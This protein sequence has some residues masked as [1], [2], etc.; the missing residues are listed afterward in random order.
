MRFTANFLIGCW[1]LFFVSLCHAQQV[2]VVDALTG[3]PIEDVRIYSKDQQHVTNQNGFFS[4]MELKENAQVYISHIGYE[5]ITM[6]TKE[7]LK[8]NLIRLHPDTQQLNEIVLS[9]ARS[10]DERKRVSK[11]VAI[12]GQK[13][14]QLQ[15]SSTSADVL[16]SASGIRIQK[17]QGGGGSPVIRGLEANRILLVVDGVRMNNAIYRSGHIQNAITIDPQTLE[18]AEIIYGPSSVGYGSDALGGVVHYYTKTP[19]IGSHKPWAF[20]MSNS[21]DTRHLHSIN[22]LDITHSKNRWASLSSV[23]LSNFGDLFMGN[24]RNHGYSDWGLVPTYSKNSREHFYETETPN[25]RPNLQRNTAYNQLDILQKF[26]F[27]TDNENQWLLNMQY[28]TSSDIPRFDKLSERR[29]GALR[30]AE[31]YYGPQ[32]RLFVS[33]RY[34]FS[35]SSK[36]LREGIIT[37]AYQ[38][39]EE[40]R[41]KRKFGS[42]DRES[43]IENLDVYSLNA[44][45][46]ART[47]PGK[48]LAY[49]LEFTHNRL[50]SVGCSQALLIQHNNIIGL[51]TKSPIATRYPSDGSTYTTVAVYGDYRVDL[52]EKSTLDAGLRFTHTR[53]KADWKDQALIDARLDMAENQNNAINASIGYVYR[54][55]SQWEWRTVVAS[56]FRAPNIDDIGKI[57]ENHGRISVPNPYLK[58]EYAYTAD[59]GITR[60]FKN[61]NAYIQLNAYYTLLDNFI[62]RDQYLIPSDSSTSSD[63]TILFMNDEVI[64]QANVNLGAANLRGAS[65]SWSLNPIKKWRYSGSFSYTYGQIKRDHLPMPSILPYFGNQEVIYQSQDLKLRFAHHF[66]S[67]KNPK[68]YSW[69]GEDGLEET[70]LINPDALE[71]IDRFAGSPSWSRFDVS[72]HYNATSS[73]TLG[74]HFF[75]ILDTHY[76]E[77]ASGISAPGRSLL[78]RIDYAF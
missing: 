32:K 72:A 58:P 16:G 64:T 76:K 18:R 66:S 56:G 49:G 27:Q 24:R 10:K 34:A 60:F 37:W 77:F 55:S 9:V 33:P 22:H 14:I 39:L 74:A 31:W 7:L 42:L 26:V 43:Q 51:G 65:M 29:E 63:E 69:G 45:F 75:N 41:V 21:Y 47:I 44:D 61:R 12:I 52:S 35:T 62:G 28:S 17:S 57:R 73:M 70:P 71:L 3:L 2:Q 11:Q 23:S 6:G 40:S 25:P 1:G 5:S 46:S 38:N 53:L 50:R 68:D 78:I 54:P 8:K 19:K 4:T 59:L 15:H 48:K 67:S 20:T 30:Y 13:N 36:W